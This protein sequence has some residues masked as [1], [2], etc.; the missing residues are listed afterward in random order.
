MRR[1]L[2]PGTQTVRLVHAESD[3]L[4]GVIADRYADTVV[5][6]LSSAGAQYW[7]E[8]LADQL[9]ELTAAQCVYERSDADVL[10]LE[11]LQPR[12]GKL[13]GDS[14]PDPLDDRRST[15]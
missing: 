1:R 9:L 7:R 8:T 14:P 13:R 2:L 6:Q 11:G 15:G 12:V 5:L 3:G 4:P 10:A